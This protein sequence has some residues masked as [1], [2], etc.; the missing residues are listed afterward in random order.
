MQLESFWEHNI[1]QLLV[2][3]I[4]QTAV[5]AHRL[6]FWNEDSQKLPWEAILEVVLL[7]HRDRGVEAFATSKL[8]FG[9]RD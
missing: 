6:L 4:D 2:L 1:N 7:G 5:L 9:H 3:R 8:D